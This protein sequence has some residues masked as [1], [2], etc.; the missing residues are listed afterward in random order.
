VT[1]KTVDERF[2]PYEM[3]IPS[4]SYETFHAIIE[5]AALLDALKRLPRLPAGRTQTVRLRLNG[6]LILERDTD[7]GC[8]RVEV[9]LVDSTHRGPELQIG[10][11]G[12]YFADALAFTTDNL[13]TARFGGPL[14]P[15]RIDHDDGRVGVIMPLRV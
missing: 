12:R 14:D 3:V 1:T 9:P 11:D 2:P 8:S 15:I 13:F 4:P 10:V 6:E 5:R 7:L